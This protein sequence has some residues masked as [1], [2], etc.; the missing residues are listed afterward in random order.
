[1]EAAA[2]GYR[3]LA[4]LAA[5]L[6][7]PRNAISEAEIYEDTLKARCAECRRAYA[8]VP[9]VERIAKH[10]LPP[11]DARKTIRKLHESVRGVRKEYE[12][13]LESDLYQGKGVN[14]VR[15]VY[16]RRCDAG[17]CCFSVFVPKEDWDM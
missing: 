15:F 10:F 12:D 14:H 3:K 11:E 1:M 7:E 8:F 2:R 5:T 13:L 4:G 9:F 6:L 17:T 16:A